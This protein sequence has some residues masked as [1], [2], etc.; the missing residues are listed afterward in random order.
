MSNN[1]NIHQWYKIYFYNKATGIGDS[2]NIFA[3]STEDAT[4]KFNELVKKNSIIKEYLVENSVTGER[5]IVSAFDYVNS[6]GIEWDSVKV[7]KRDRPN[8][9]IQIISIEY[10]YILADGACNE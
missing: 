8:Y 4:N 5:T 9:D 7:I 3:T 10:K 6:C 1:R 2:W